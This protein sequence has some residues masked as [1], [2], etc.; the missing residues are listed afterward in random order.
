MN[1]DKFKAL[2]EQKIVQLQALQLEARAACDTVVLDQSRVGRLSR[3]DA[4][5]SQ[6]MNQAAQRRREAE[7]IRL[8]SALQRLGQEAYG[9]CEDCDEPISEGRLMI[10]LAADYCVQCAGSHE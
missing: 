7:L 4:M 10:D 5:Q 9:F 6:A 8:Q 3:M 2:I 1:P